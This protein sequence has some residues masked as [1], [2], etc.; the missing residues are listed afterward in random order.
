VVVQGDRA[1]ASMPA[2]SARLGIAARP[3]IGFSPADVAR[4]GG[5]DQGDLAARVR[6]STTVTSQAYL[7]GAEADFATVGPET[8]RGVVTT[9]YLGTIDLDRA[10]ART[11][12]A[13]RAELQQA[14][15]SGLGAAAGHRLGASLWLDRRG[16]VRR[17]DLGYRVRADDDEQTVTVSFEFFDFGRPV[18]VEPP[19]LDQVTPFR[20]VADRLEG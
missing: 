3:W 16:R 5:E 2:L 7:H 12:R 11:P 10:V 1:W 6:Q 14:I 13:Q 18:I 17:E 4:V 19:P 8:L 15:G 20:E 9:H